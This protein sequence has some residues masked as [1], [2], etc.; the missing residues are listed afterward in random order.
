[1]LTRTCALVSTLLILS[2]CGL[3]ENNVSRGDGFSEEF[4]LNQ[5]YGIERHGECKDVADLSNWGIEMDLSDPTLRTAVSP[6]MNVMITGKKLSLKWEL[7]A[8]GCATS[9]SY[10]GDISYEATIKSVEVDENSVLLDLEFHEMDVYVGSVGF[11][12][13]LKEQ[14]YC[15]F[16]KWKLLG[17]HKFQKCGAREFPYREKMKIS[18]LDSDRYQVMLPGESEATEFHRK[19]PLR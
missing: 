8:R 7:Y 17:T 3:N 10:M 14:V 9:K 15:N 11:F 5:Q 12:M 19:R 6:H 13:M 4:R 18:L 1:M 2:S 16:S